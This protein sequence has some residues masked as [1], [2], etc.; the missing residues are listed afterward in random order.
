[1]TLDALREEVVRFR[2]ASGPAGGRAGA[3]GK[4]TEPARLVA[5]TE[6][7]AI[8]AQREPARNDAEAVVPAQAGPT[9]PPEGD[10]D[11]MAIIDRAKGGDAEA[12]GELYDRN[13][14]TVYRY[15]Y[16]R[17]GSVALA[18]DLVSE[19]FLRALRRIDSFTYQGRDVA[20]WF[21][22][23]A[24]NLIADHFKSS[25]FRLELTTEDMV[26]ATDDRVLDEDPAAQV[27]QAMTNRALVAAVK[28][29]GSEQQECI[30]LRLLQGMSVS[31]T[32][33]AMG[34]N[35]G[36]IKA[37]QYRGVRALARLLPPD[38]L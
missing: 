29:L 7:P 21:I 17:V 9:G 5:P 30:V 31:E 15:V 32:A 25:R 19:T 1:L 37:L 27:M 22:T 11:M 8:A 14:D 13:V 20:A 2:A 34:K 10:L 16:Y 28:Q 33:I 38:S 35:E 23:I 24:R 12:F 36:A 26:S 18:E 3:A 6:T 4:R